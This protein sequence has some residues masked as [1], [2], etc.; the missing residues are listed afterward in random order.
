MNQKKIRTK[1]AICA[2]AYERFSA[3]LI[4]DAEYDYLCRQIDV[5]V[6]TDRPDLDDW[7]REHYTDYSGVCFMN[8]PDYDRLEE[9]AYWCV[10]AKNVM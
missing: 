1:A 9:I 4:S 2:I 6:A 8:H 3:S 10:R 5:S 7:F